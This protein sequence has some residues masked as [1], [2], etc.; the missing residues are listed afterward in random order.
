MHLVSALAFSTVLRASGL[1]VKGFSFLEGQ[2]LSAA[3]YLS[4]LLGQPGSGSAG[5]H[6]A[7]EE[8]GILTLT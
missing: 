2:A 8:L 1:G 5:P 6:Q 3:L 7:L 4:V